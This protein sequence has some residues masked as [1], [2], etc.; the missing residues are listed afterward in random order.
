MTVIG[1]GRIGTSVGLALVDQ[2]E[3]IFRIGHDKSSENSRQAE[4]LGAFD[5]VIP[6][7]YASIEKS[8]IIVLAIPVD[9]ALETLK[10]IAKDIKEGSVVMHMSSNLVAA[11]A[12][13]KELL[14]AERHFVTLAPSLNPE[15]MSETQSGPTAAHADLFKKSVITIAAPYGSDPGVVKLA[16]DLTAMLGAKPYFADPLEFDGLTAGSNTLPKLVAAALINAVVEQPGW[17]EGRKLAGRA[18]V[19][20]SEPLCHLDE[21]KV[22]G[23]SAML[24]RDNSMRVL[25][26]MIISL[27]E[28]R[29]ALANEDEEA[30]KG[31]I[32]KA[33]KG[34]ET[35]LKDRYTTAWEKGGESP[36]LPSAGESLSRMFLGGL[37]RKRETPKK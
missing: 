21:E 7:L 26:N 29:E 6:N 16:A 24:N 18:F 2:K 31:L 4:K 1:T 12:Q 32:D 11:C 27:R 3:Q 19:Q 10:L 13:A 25:D 36:A 33:I 22:W 5:K 28:L 23:K 34:R 8:D 9:E 15:Y 14:P 17:Q 30:L 35:F 20:I 37:A